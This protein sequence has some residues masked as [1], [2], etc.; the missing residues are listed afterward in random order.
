MSNYEFDNLKFSIHNEEDKWVYF[1]HF[2]LIE[3]FSKP[4]DPLL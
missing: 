1:M 3:T 4:I 2:L